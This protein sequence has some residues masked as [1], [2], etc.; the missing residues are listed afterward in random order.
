MLQIHTMNTIHKLVNIRHLRKC[1]GHAL[2]WSAS[3]VLGTGLEYIVNMRM[4]SLWD[5]GGTEAALNS[6]II[7]IQLWIK[8][9]AI[10]FIN[11]AHLCICNS[12]CI[13]GKN[14]TCPRDHLFFFIH[15][16]FSNKS[17]VSSNEN[18]KQ[19][20]NTI[21]TSGLLL[22]WP[23][24]FLPLKNLSCKLL[25]GTNFLEEQW[26]YFLKFYNSKDL[27]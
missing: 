1:K 8:R 10:P 3:P 14:L 20:P 12:S 21:L 4:S 26:Q 11:M 17:S 16:F 7:W 25:A 13:P 24:S 2:R 23:T 9:L 5:H 22:P 18:Y 19:S 15:E 6:Q 27:F